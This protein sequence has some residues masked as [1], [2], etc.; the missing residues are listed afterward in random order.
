MVLNMECV[1]PKLEDGLCHNICLEVANVPK[2]VKQCENA[3]DVP[4]NVQR[5]VLRNVNVNVTEEVCL[6]LDAERVD[7]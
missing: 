1:K 3:A 5:N 7:S 6:P 2:K 4:R